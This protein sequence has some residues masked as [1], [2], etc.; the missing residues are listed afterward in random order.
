[1]K[2]KHTT[3]SLVFHLS[4]MPATTWLT[5]MLFDSE[6]WCHR[7]KN[8]RRQI[9]ESISTSWYSQPMRANIFCGF[10]IS[11]VFFSVLEIPYWMRGYRP[12]RP[13]VKYT[14]IYAN[15]H[16]FFL[17]IFFLSPGTA[18]VFRYL[19]V[20]LQALTMR[21]GEK[22]WQKKEL[23]KR[24][25]NVERTGAPDRCSSRAN[26][27]HMHPN[28]HNFWTNLNKFHRYLLFTVSRSLHWLFSRSDGEETDWAIALIHF[29][30]PL[31]DYIHYYE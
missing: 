10:G 19:T 14:M 24:N 28:E 18:T 2:S 4:Q 8:Q 23:E 25:K 16:V 15:S 17:L 22:K 5:T 27:S 9:T 26:P 29:F 31:I 11:F 3:N 20:P 1:M 30:L 7:I 6:R 12:K 21:N 13:N